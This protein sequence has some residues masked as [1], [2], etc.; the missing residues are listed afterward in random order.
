MLYKRA[1]RRACEIRVKTPINCGGGGRLMNKRP[2]RDL[3]DSIIIVVVVVATAI[4]T[5]AVVYWLCV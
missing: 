2:S 3:I 4:A 5:V 1:A